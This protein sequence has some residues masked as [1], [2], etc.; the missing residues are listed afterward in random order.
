MLK[1][2]KTKV[3]ITPIFDPD[4]TRSGLIIIPDQAKERCD[5]GVV[6]YVGPDV[7]LVKPGDYVIFSGYSGDLTFLE[8]EGVFIVMHEE[9]IIAK[10]ADDEID[11]TDIPGL[12]FKSVDG[13]YFLCTY[14]FVIEM[15]TQAF[16][17]AKWQ[18]FLGKKRNLMH[19]KMARTTEAG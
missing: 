5:Q 11:N 16:K 13:K 15:L 18:N 19:N 4:T 7:T 1:V 8:D 12:Y 17:D 6:K 14:E 10:L 2:A 9:F 3:V